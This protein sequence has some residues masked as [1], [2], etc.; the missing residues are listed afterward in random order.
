MARSTDACLPRPRLWSAPGKRNWAGSA[1]LGLMGMAALLL[2][3]SE[4]ARDDIID[5]V[6]FLT[7]GSTMLIVASS[8]A[9]TRVIARRRSTRFV[10]RGTIPETGEA[11]IVVPYSM[12]YF[13]LYLGVPGTGVVSLVASGVRERSAFYFLVAIGFAVLPAYCFVQICRKKIVRGYLAMSPSGIYHRSWGFISFAPWEHVADVEPGEGRGQFIEVQV[14][15]NT[16]SWSRRTACLLGPSSGSA[17]LSVRG[18]FLS[19][20]P[21]LVYYALLFYFTNPD[22]RS[23][24]GCDAGVQRLRKVDIPKSL[25]HRYAY[26]ATIVGRRKLYGAEVVKGGSAQRVRNQSTSGT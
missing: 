2:G 17:G 1:F 24:L 5:G 16:E 22:A 14:G 18:M 15:T 4:L 12:G 23:E 21:A 25:L 3:A 9:L 11:A 8:G 20:D 6:Y 10:R 19:V 7:G 13:W 26:R